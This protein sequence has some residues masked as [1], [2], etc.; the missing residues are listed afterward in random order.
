MP[1]AAE[2]GPVGLAFEFSEDDLAI[3]QA[4][5][6]ASAREREADCI[7]WWRAFPRLLAEGE[8]GR[9]GLIHEGKLVSVWDTRGDAVQA[10]YDKFGI[11]APLF[12]GAITQY[13]LKK[14]K[15]FLAQERAKK[16]P[17]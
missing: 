4:A 10:G 14:L 11:D 13:E 2:A 17:S 3:F 9:Y 7:A 5:L 15:L 8:E 16:C 12:I 6:P 1:P